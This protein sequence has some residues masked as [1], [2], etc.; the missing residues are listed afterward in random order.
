[1]CTIKQ[2]S[3]IGGRNVRRVVPVARL[4][5]TAVLHCR[6]TELNFYWN[7]FDKRGCSGPNLSNFSPREQL[8]E[9]KRYSGVK[10]KIRKRCQR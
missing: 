8:D 5:R 7:R 4:L 3:E 6:T 2:K 9:K 10:K 1:M